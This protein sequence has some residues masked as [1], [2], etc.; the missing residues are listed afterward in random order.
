MVT[1]ATAPEYAVYRNGQRLMW[2]S[3]ATR[4]PPLVEIG[5]IELG[6]EIRING[7]K[8]TKREAKSQ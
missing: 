3:L 4:Y 8:L 1:V 7:K 5:M 2:G 6:Y